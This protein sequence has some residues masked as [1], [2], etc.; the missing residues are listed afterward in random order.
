MANHLGNVVATISDRKKANQS[1]MNFEIV[2]HHSPQ[3]QNAQDYFPFGMTMP[4]RSFVDPENSYR[5]G[6]QNQE[7]VKELW[8]GAISYKYRIEDP[9]LGRFFSVDPLA[10]KY[11]H[12]SPYA[13]S[14]NRVIDGVELE[15]LE[16]APYDNDGNKIDISCEGWEAN[17]SAYRWEGY[18]EIEQ[19]SYGGNTYNSFDELKLSE[20]ISD[21]NL[22]SSK[23]KRTVG[24]IPKA[25]TVDQA[26]TTSSS[27]NSINSSIITTTYYGVS[28]GNQPYT[29]TSNF[30]DIQT[31]WL[32][33]AES[34]LGVKELTNN[35]DGP[36]VQA[37]LKTCGLKG[38]WA[39]CAAFVNWVF[40]ETGIQSM[41]LKDNPAGAINWGEW[42]MN[43]DKPAL[44]AVATM[45]RKGGGHVAFVIGMTP[46]G[47]LILLG[48]NQS[49]SVSY[50]TT[51][52]SKIVKFRYPSGYTPQ[53]NIPIINFG[54]KNTTM[55]YSIKQ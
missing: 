27:S 16:W 20:D 44:G 36:Q 9:R 17:V 39:W 6:F 38:D 52:A 3:I 37:Y 21:L 25:G 10:P 53:Y 11:P 22:N 32:D 50:M 7:T 29:N 23:I 28:N 2:S 12:N 47:D 49:H 13:F 41:D 55:H 4:G 43:L 1:L 31:P 18:D 34:Q 5:Y 26:M 40:L 24:Y 54:K 35:N 33:E 46:G 19:W 51:E 8:N 42:G 14:E 30:L 48:G 45:K 15:G